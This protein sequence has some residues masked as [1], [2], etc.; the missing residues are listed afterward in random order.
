[1]LNSR[2]EVSNREL[3]K[4]EDFKEQVN[5]L[6]D[7]AKVKNPEAKPCA[8]NKDFDTCVTGYNKKLMLWY[9]DKTGSTK[10]VEKR[11]D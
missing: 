10:V 3:Q 11:I 8:G 1:M 9:N 7:M 2:D 6:V 4:A 5:D